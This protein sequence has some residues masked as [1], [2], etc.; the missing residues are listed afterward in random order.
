MGFWSSFRLI[1]FHAD[2]ID[3][4]ECDIDIKY[5]YKLD[6][7]VGFG[8]TSNK[9]TATNGD[10]LYALAHSY[11]PPSADSPLFSPQAYHEFYVG[12]SELDGDK[13]VM[14]LKQQIDLTGI[15]FNMTCP[16]CI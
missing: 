15:Q 11:H 2:Y 13:V 1:P 14:H 10:L 8:T 9:L 7:V 5:I 3:Y 4:V 6:K 12:S 16:I